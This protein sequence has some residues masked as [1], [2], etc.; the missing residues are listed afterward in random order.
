MALAEQTKTSETASAF[1]ESADISLQ[2]LGGF[3]PESLRQSWIGRKRWR[4]NLA[5][6]TFFGFFV[7]LTNKSN[8]IS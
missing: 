3:E 1:A 5:L 7:S 8:E 4:S 2:D 6:D